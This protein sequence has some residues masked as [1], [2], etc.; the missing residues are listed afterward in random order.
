MFVF[1]FVG[2]NPPV[3]RP[4]GGAVREEG[5][6]FFGGRRPRGGQEVSWRDDASTSVVSVGKPS[7]S[8]LP[9]YVIVSP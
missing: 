6:R 3:G 9:R 4:V 1:V 7:V 5:A 2:L 8:T